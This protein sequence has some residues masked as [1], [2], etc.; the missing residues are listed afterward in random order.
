MENK[1]NKKQ[2]IIFSV[3]ALVFII[4]SAVFFSKILSVILFSAVFS[5][6]ILPLVVRYEKNCVRSV[7][8]ICAFLFVFSLLTAT[9]MLLVPSVINQTSQLL[10]GLPKYFVSIEEFL[11]RFLFLQKIGVSTETL[12]NKIFTFIMPKGEFD[13]GQTFSTISMWLLTPI[14]S[15]YF[16]LEREKIRDIFLFLLPQKIKE[17]SIFAFKKI[18]SQ[19]RDYVFSQVL[20]IIV[21]SAISAL[22]LL[23]F[24][25]EYPLALGIIVGLFNI[26]P[27]IGP[28][29]GSVPAILIASTG[30][31]KRIILAIVLMV[32]IQQIDNILVHPI[33]IGKT[34]KVHPLVVL[35]TVLIGNELFGL[36]GMMLSVPVYISLKIVLKEIYAYF[37]EKNLKKSKNLQI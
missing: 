31:I 28:I 17:K 5:Y 18:N 12:K 13:F 37:S 24:S 2:T 34:V 26:V 11:N 23:A 22:L 16:L 3:V 35:L 1:H 14:I 32:F 19:L 4:V 9:I 7:S 20:L 36:W 33:I 15:F 10:F 8:I 30:G 21:I 29:L 6:L 25:F 27:Y